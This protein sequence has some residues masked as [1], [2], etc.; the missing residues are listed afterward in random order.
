MTALIFMIIIAAVAG[1]AHAI[2]AIIRKIRSGGRY[3]VSPLVAAIAEA[4]IHKARLE[5]AVYR[6]RYRLRTKTDDDLPI[7][8]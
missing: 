6:N 4:R 7:V 2:G 8:R 1:A 3:L 5:A